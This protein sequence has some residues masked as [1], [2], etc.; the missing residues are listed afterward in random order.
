MN[1]KLTFAVLA[2]I[3]LSTALV[4]SVLNHIVTRQEMTPE[5]I[6][7]D[8]NDFF[9]T[10]IS[11]DGNYLGAGTSNTS[12][13]YIFQGNMSL[14]DYSVGNVHS[15]AMSSDGKHV[16]VGAGTD[17]YLFDSE[18]SSPLLKYRVGYE[19][20][21]VVI[22]P[23]GKHVVVGAGSSVRQANAESKLYV[24]EWGK[25][26]PTWTKTLQGVLESLSI[27]GNGS[28]IVASTSLPG[29]MYVFVR[30][31]ETLLWSYSFGDWGG[32]VRISSGGDYI[33][34]IGGSEDD[35]SLFQF[36]RER[37]SQRYQKLILEPPSHR[38]LSASSNGSIFAI[39][40]TSRNELI[41]FD[42][43]IQPYS[44]SSIHRVSLP[45]SRVS[46]FMSSD[47]RYIFIGTSEGI[48]VYEYFNNRLSLTRQY[49]Y[50]KPTI[51]DVASSPDGRYLV[52]IGHWRSPVDEHSN[53]YF[54]DS[55]RETAGPS[56]LWLQWAPLILV[57][58]VVIVGVVAF[59][60]YKRGL[61]Q[62]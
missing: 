21:L 54:F 27:S 10:A 29:V 40:Y 35:Y 36:L 25:T 46:M 11:A 50:N 33:V 6:Y 22:S 7:E 47:G 60:F 26:I 41:L 58:I 1:R 13:F 61:K 17:F 49:T 19:T 15:I 45:A 51:Y 48:F 4:V 38:G 32:G 23:D 2:I 18:V 56:D 12:R 55:F 30:E 24:F 53:I 3:L 62:S 5:W 44:P 28:Y 42:M 8:G 52:A 43:N 20:S 16:A 39:S 9:R 37:E 57:I 34:A 31:Q 14:W 59:V